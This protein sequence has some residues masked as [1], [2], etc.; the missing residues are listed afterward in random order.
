MFRRQCG[1]ASI[2]IED[3]INMLIREMIEKHRLE[4]RHL[5]G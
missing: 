2:A 1:T 4:A 5:D 3:T